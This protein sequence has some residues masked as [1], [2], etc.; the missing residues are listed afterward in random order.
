MRLSTNMIFNMSTQSILQQQSSLAHV[1]QQLAS[2][3]K[4]LTPADAPRDAAQSLVLSNALAMN[5]QYGATREIGRR[6]LSAQVVEFK[7][8]TN[9]LNAAKPLLVQASNGTLANPD[10]E[11]VATELEGVYNQ[12]LNSANAQDGNGNYIFS[13]YELNRPPFEGG[14][15]NLVYSGD[16]GELKLQVNGNRIMPV[17][18]TAKEIFATVT[19][20]AKYVTTADSANGGTVKVANIR[21]TDPSDAQIKAGDDY[22]IQ[23]TGI[24]STSA[25]THDITY[26]VTNTT[27]GVEAA[28]QTVSYD[29]SSDAPFTIT[30]GDSNDGLSVSFE[31][32]P[33]LNDSFSVVQ[34]DDLGYTVKNNGSS[35]TVG[36]E[37]VDANDVD[38]AARD[39][40]KLEF[41]S[42]A[43]PT[44]GSYD[45]QY[46]ITNTTDGTSHSSGTITHD[47]GTGPLSINTGHNGDGLTLKVSDVPAAG[48]VFDV[49]PASEEHTN[50]L[51][52]LA[53]VID[54]LKQGVNTEHDKAALRNTIDSA[55]RKVS[56]SLNNVS[57]IQAE[58]GSKINELESLSSIGSNRFL[59]YKTT[60]SSLTD[61]NYAKAASDYVLGKVALQMAQKTFTDIQKLSIFRMV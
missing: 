38:V 40:Y 17:S 11:A 20:G 22:K 29:A 1:R 14:R 44:A 46:T 16:A 49:V 47:F 23:F 18:H 2:G 25:P 30:M 8:I 61:L 19:D 50:I 31:G 10:L 13:G 42:V 56:N 6:N 7:S 21:I 5:E 51:N 43:G 55:L 12:L 39:H 32:V 28:P 58:T 27:T 34:G 52:T 15:G 35:A 48:D 57:T 41:T 37:I 45:V 4:F 33:Q 24:D 60:L 3:Q 26:V 54:Q 59:N 36:V 53:G 9:A